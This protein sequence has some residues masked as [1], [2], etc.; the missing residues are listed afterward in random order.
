MNYFCTLFPSICLDNEYHYVLSFLNAGLYFFKIFII[1][2]ELK[3]YLWNSLSFQCFEGS[4][5]YYLHVRLDPC[6][7]VRYS[8]SKVLCLEPTFPWLIYPGEKIT[9]WM[10]VWHLY[11]RFVCFLCPNLNCLPSKHFFCPLIPYIA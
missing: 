7:P 10:E 6:A 8:L 2:K 9:A 1:Y 4:K 11:W 3:G 5:W